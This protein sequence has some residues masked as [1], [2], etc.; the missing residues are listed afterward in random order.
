MKFKVLYKHMYKHNKDLNIYI[1]K[2]K[3]LSLNNDAL[4]MSYF[5]RGRGCT[6]WDRDVTSR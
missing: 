5:K 3:D 2:Q 6:K 4:I 1:C